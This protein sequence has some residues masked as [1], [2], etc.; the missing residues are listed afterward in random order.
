MKKLKVKLIILFF[1]ILPLY[2]ISQFKETINSK[3][4][5]SIDS[6]MMQNFKAD[7]PGAVLLVAKDGEIIYK[8]AFGKASLELNVPMKTDMVFQIGSITKQFT[9]IAILKLLELG[10]LSLEDDLKKYIPDYPTHG[11][12]ITLHHLLNQS[13]GIKE[14]LSVDSKE[15]VPYKE[16]KPL[17]LIEIFKNQPM[18]F[19]PGEKWSYSNSNY[20]IL[21]YVIEK[22][23]G[24]SYNEFLKEYIFKPAGMNSSTD[25]NNEII[26]KDR[27]PG[28]YQGKSGTF[29]NARYLH[30]SYPYASGS[31]LST[32]EDMFKWQQA[33]NNNI[34]IK[35]ETK[36]KAFTNYA[37]QGKETNYG[38]GWS[39]NEIGSSMSY[40]HS[41]GT[42]GFSSNG[43]YLPGEKVYVI[44]LSNCVIYPVESISTLVASYVI[45]NP[46][47]YPPAIKLTNEELEKF[48]GSY[49][50]EDGRQITVEKDGDEIATIMYSLKRI[51]KPYKQNIFYTPGSF[52]EFEFILN[53]K[54]E[55]TGI[56]YSNRKEV[57]KGKKVK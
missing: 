12:E 30:L 8:K 51:I 2:A 26:I 1:F 6:I 50:L 43:I 31:I 23:S 7:A 45:G 22:A 46:P 10:K 29:Y 28:Y 33:L 21:G 32:V 19:K 47:V 38:Y 34:L 55:I 53:D 24:L 3:L 15:N 20:S 27:L 54:Q 4:E 11:N 39:L 17:E 25:G 18:Q 44:I 48:I 16:Y 14:L 40:E 9:A 35:E 57:N 42:R 5:N 13:S 37:I 52:E 56:V 36:S 41:G 49:L